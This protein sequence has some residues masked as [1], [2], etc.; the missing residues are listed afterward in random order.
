MISTNLYYDWYHL[1]RTFKKYVKPDYLVVDIGASNPPRTQEL[2]SYCR[3][4]IGIEYYPQRLLADHHNIIYQQGDWQ[5]LSTTITPNSVDILIASHVIEHIPDDHRAISESY[6]V[7]KS[8]GVAI[9]TTPNRHRL[10]RRALEL[11]TGPQ[12]FPCGEHQREYNEIDL[13]NL[14]N[15]SSFSNFYITP[16]VLGINGANISFSFTSFPKFLRPLCNY[17]QLVLIKK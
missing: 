9:I 8:G 11:F 1:I 6:R 16:I 2:A 7:L 10:V 17:W 12:K 13:I 14:V 5:H 3:Q 15:N 4:V